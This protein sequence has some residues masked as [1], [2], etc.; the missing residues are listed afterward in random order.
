[1]PLSM[2]LKLFPV[3]VLIDSDTGET[4]AKI[5]L[6]LS[7]HWRDARRAVINEV[8]ASA[9]TMPARLESV[10]DVWLAYGEC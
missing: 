10:R 2:R 6:Q 8:E 9:P 7:M 4:H 3:T 1:M 5:Q